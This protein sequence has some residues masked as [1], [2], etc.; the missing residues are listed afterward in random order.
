MIPQFRRRTNQNQHEL[1]R[2]SKKMTSKS[3]VQ[4]IQS[5][6]GDNKDLSVSLISGDASFRKYY[7]VLHRSEL[8]IAVDSPP[9]QE[10]N[11]EFLDIQAL[12]A[13]A[14]VAVP[15]IIASDLLQGF[16]LQQDLGDTQLFQII[17]QANAI[18]YY[19]KAIDMMLVMQSQI[20]THSLP[21]YNDELL[22][23]EMMLFKDWL[24]GKHCEVNLTSNQTADLVEAFNF[25]KASALR[26]Q[27]R[28]V[29]RDF[30]SRNLMVCEDD[31]LVTI[32]FQ[33]AVCGPVTYDLV[34]LLRDCY[35]VWPKP[36][37]EHLVQYAYDGMINRGLTQVTFQQFWQDFDLMGVQRHL[38]ASGIFCRL[39]HRDGKSSYL[40]D[41][42][43]TLQYITQI[44]CRYDEL[45]ILSELLDHY[46][47]PHF[48]KQHS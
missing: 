6:F 40:A 7:R 25:L 18:F 3:F 33:D 24:I 34:S 45:N 35:L 4:W 2:K 42:P 39:H 1:N 38:K 46:I 41:I 17:D 47:L 11:Q 22:I 37:V 36:L 10:K 8:F 15:E 48:V 26:Q 29:H 27:Q 19:Q 32:D 23:Q 5:Q 44:A 14:G 30:H 21:E 31:Q 16:I 13:N 20:D 28:F 43:R 12:M 9:S